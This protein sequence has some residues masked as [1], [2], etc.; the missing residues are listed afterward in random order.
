M[1]SINERVRI[2]AAVIDH[3]SW[4]NQMLSMNPVQP[5][6]LSQRPFLQWK[7]KKKQ[8]MFK[9]D[10]FFNLRRCAVFCRER[11]SALETAHQTRSQARRGRGRLGGNVFLSA[12][13]HIYTCTTS[14]K[15]VVFLNGVFVC[16]C[17]RLG[18]WPYAEVCTLW[19]PFHL[20][21]LDWCLDCYT[22]QLCLLK[23][24]SHSSSTPNSS[25]FALCW[26][27]KGLHH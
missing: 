5:R 2:Q 22:G 9:E 16:V 25:F 26:F 23:Q 8:S 7:G 18:S 17:V 10:P 27:P 13:S 12:T 3:C 19:M 24:F 11:L 4:W 1:R 21:Y 14:L 15:K 20:H 6:L